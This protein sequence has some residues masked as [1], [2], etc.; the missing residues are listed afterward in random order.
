MSTQLSP[1]YPPSNR[2]VLLSDL[3]DFNLK[4]NALLPAFV[5]SPA[6][7]SVTEISHLEFARAVHRSAH[8]L[9]ASSS[10]DGQVVAVIAKTD[11]L[12]YQALIAGMLRSGLV[13]SEIITSLA[14]LRS[15]MSCSHSL[16]LRV[17]PL[18]QSSRCFRRH[19]VIASSLPTQASR[20]S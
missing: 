17:T 1:V 10:L 14:K 12:L 19:P 2:S 3:P 6:P 8:A 7:G 11:T 4:H 16:S 18:K 20:L 9:R 13:V 5:Y 15:Y